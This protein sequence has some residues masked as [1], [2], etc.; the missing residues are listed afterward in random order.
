MKRT[1]KL[2]YVNTD[3]SRRDMSLLS[4][5][6]IRYRRW[7]AR[8]RFSG[9][10]IDGG[11]ITLGPE[12]CEN[13]QVLHP[14]RLRIGVGVVI[15]GDF[16]CNA[17]G[18]VTIGKHVHIAKGVTIYSH[19][20][21]FRSTAFVPYG[22]QDILKPVTIGDAVWVGANVDIAPGANI[23]EGAIIAMGSVVFGSIPRCAVARGN[24]AVVVGSRDKAIFDELIRNHR[25]V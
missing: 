6:L 3:S 18:G 13:F 10:I 17:L 2:R 14:S 7:L 21:D 22:E 23:G 8:R 19:N 15:N 1:L 20:H 11:R 16:F 12:C 5:I 4:K 25:Y 9:C 24:P